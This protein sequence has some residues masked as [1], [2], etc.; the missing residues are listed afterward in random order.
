MHENINDLF[1]G[2]EHA[3]WDGVAYSHHEQLGKDHGRRERRQCRVITDPEELAYVD[4]HR[5]WD[6]LGAVAK[7][8]YP[9]DSAEGSPEDTR[10]Y[11]C[12]YSGY[13]TH[14][15]GGAE[16]LEHRKQPA[17][18]VG[19]SLGRGSQSSVRGGLRRPSPGGDQAPGPE[20]A[21]TGTQ[22]QSR[23]QS[24]TQKGRLGLRLPAQSP[25]P[26]KCDCPDRSPAD[27]RSPA[28][29]PR[30]IL[31]QARPWHQRYKTSPPLT[32]INCFLDG[33]RHFPRFWVRVLLR[34]G[35]VL[36][37]S[38]VCPDNIEEGPGAGPQLG[39]PVV[40][41]IVGV[42]FVSASPELDA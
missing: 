7:V 1:A 26:M 30:W 35:T 21:Q 12:S 2:Q 22:R 29:Y 42:L 27:M 6:N 3:G 37:A 15:A 32:R 4:P 8:S 40:V 31:W 24:Q 10:Y 11:I 41:K 18:G 33:D 28:P 23:H 16:P 17:L 13:A 36:C 20:L 5:Q 19:R 25:I 39:F 38:G 34:P 14:A 9:R